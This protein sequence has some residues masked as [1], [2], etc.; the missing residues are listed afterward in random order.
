[1]TTLLHPITSTDE[2][3]HYWI[4]EQS[5]LQLNEL[6]TLFKWDYKEGTPEQFNEYV[7]QKYQTALNNGWSAHVE[8]DSFKLL[9][10]KVQEWVMGLDS[11][12]AR[13]LKDAFFESPLYPEIEWSDFV[14]AAYLEQE[15]S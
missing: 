1:M 5:A 15:V 6:N 13:D 8:V 11:E 4:K 3:F 7:Y 14:H 2:L 10:L 12:A 9:P